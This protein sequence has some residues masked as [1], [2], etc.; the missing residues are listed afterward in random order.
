MGEKR[1]SRV[2]EYG[3]SVYS[4]HPSR[5]VGSRMPSVVFVKCW[6]ATVSSG[7]LF[8]SMRRIGV[9]VIRPAATSLSGASTSP[10]I[11]PS[12]KC[13][14]GMGGLRSGPAGSIVTLR[15]PIGSPS[16]VK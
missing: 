3:C 9:S 1:V 12:L 16:S 11:V 8:S 10:R 5:R 2:S 13:P 15:C 6:M 4:P 7:S 14:T